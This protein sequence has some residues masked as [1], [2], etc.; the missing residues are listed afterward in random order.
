MERTGRASHVF[1][2]GQHKGQPDGGQAATW[3]GGELRERVKSR[4][5]R[6]LLAL[7]TS[8]SKVKRI[9]ILQN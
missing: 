1:E 9:L 2:L 5:V 7:S 3:Q 6:K 8:S 4:I